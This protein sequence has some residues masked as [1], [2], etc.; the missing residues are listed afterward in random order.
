MRTA[1]LI[2]LAT[3]L[4]AAELHITVH[5]TVGDPLADI[6]VAARAVGD[7]PYKGFKTRTNARGELRMGNFETGEYLVTLRDPHRSRSQFHYPTQTVEVSVPDGE[8]PVSFEFTMPALRL[9]RVRGKVVGLAQLDDPSHKHMLFVE[10]KE[11]PHEPPPEM[12][13]TAVIVRADGTFALPWLPRGSYDLALG[14]LEGNN[15][16]YGIRRVP[17]GELQ[18]NSDL[19]GLLLTAFPSDSNSSTRTSGKLR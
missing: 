11:N 2:G 5:N 6:D 8:A 1:L 9:F 16:G 17:L 4:P 15:F 7:P 10:P 14:Q 19:G 12:A 3:T 13:R 18:V